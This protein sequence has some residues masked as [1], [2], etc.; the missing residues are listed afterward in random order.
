MT[1]SNNERY[2]VNRWYRKRKGYAVDQIYLGERVCGNRNVRE[3]GA[4]NG[5]IGVIIGQSVT[6]IGNRQRKVFQVQFANNP[7][8][9]Y[10]SWPHPATKKDDKRH[11][12]HP[13]LVWATCLT[14]NK[15]QGSEWDNM[16]VHLTGKWLRGRPWATRKWL[17]TCVSRGRKT[18]VIYGNERL[19]KMIL[20]NVADRFRITML[21]ELLA[22]AFMR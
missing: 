15:C 12:Q 11:G 10:Y 6:D 9:P 2:A 4:R 22:K 5:E 1:T 13:N 14:G 7:K 21:D 8:L 18:A 3:T 20:A 19:V 16:I 17:Y